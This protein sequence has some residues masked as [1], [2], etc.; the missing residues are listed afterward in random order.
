MSL[1]KVKK[2]WFLQK[3]A[4]N[5]DDFFLEPPTPFF[6][7]FY[8]TSNLHKIITRG[9]SDI[10][11]TVLES[12]RSI[13]FENKNCINKIMNFHPFWEPKRYDAKNGA[14]LVQKFMYTVWVAKR[15]KFQIWVW[16]WKI[17]TLSFLK[18]SRECL[19]DP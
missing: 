15:P 7:L 9:P 19:R 2:S 13:L 18:P 5:C 4:R 1:W 14:F 8:Q 6:G 16:E 10:P 17:W 12:S 3:F 11:G